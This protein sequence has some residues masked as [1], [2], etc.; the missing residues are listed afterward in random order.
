[1]ARR[2]R[3]GRAMS[4]Y[5]SAWV[6]ALWCAAGCAAFED[7][8]PGGSELTSVEGAEHTIEYDSFV[9]V[10]PGASDAAVQDAVRRQIKS[11]LGAL[12]ERGIGVLD[13][14]ARSNLDP[15]GWVRTPLQVIDADDAVVGEVER[16]TFH[17][18]DT[19]VVERDRIPGGPIT[20]PLLAGDYPARYAELVPACTDEA[21]PAAYSLWYHY[22][23]GRWAC[24]TRIATEQAAI[25]DAT[26]A[27]PD[28][29]TQI[30]VIDRDRL[31]ITTRASLARVDDP[32]SLYPEYDQLWGFTGSTD[33]TMVV[34]YAFFGVDRD[35]ADP[36]DYGLRELMRF[37]RTMRDR[38]PSLRVTHT[39][40]FAMLLDFWI[41][42]ARVPG[43][44]FDMVEDW[45]IDGT[46]FPAG[47]TAAGRAQLLA[48]V[49]E[50]FSERWIYWELPVEVSDGATTR[51]MTVQLRTF[52]G[53]EDGSHEVRQRATW[54][55]LEAFWHGDVF[56]Y[57]GHS[58][59]G[60]G[61]LEPV[62]Y[63]T[64]NFPDRYQV[65]L[66][67]S[68]LSF[69]YYDQDFLDV[70]PDG[71]A[72]LDIVTNGLAAYWHGMGEATA[73]YVISLIDGESKT[74]REL[75]AA[76]RVDLPW[77]SG[78]DPMRVVN[79]ELDNAF[80]AAARPLTVRVM[81]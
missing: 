63:A 65:M 61:P 29:N 70:H 50:R 8:A 14:D 54:R 74:W 68:C 47:T 33:R 75:L 77:A 67:N 22:H 31:F 80:D 7:A 12:R 11:S 71:T 4:G 16:V 51:R 45:V 44:T 13:R 39:A 6:L 41:D 59:F 21:A 40:P 46:G 66:V 43:V 2:L 25:A 62:H 64:R 42:G 38:F 69:N 9:Y 55:Y 36:G 15:S 76:M 34:V 17:Y 28:A 5:R 52:Y 18:R 10:A 26:A 79:G 56:A 1:M 48:Q 23:P 37:Q 27:L 24:R 20:L 78:Y 72:K 35:E 30:A 49:V 58:H 57:T 32:P 81:E 3:C 19:A 73:G 60:H 53:Y